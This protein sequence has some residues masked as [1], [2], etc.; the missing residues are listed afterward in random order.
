MS[1]SYQRKDIHR[2]SVEEGL[3]VPL[4]GRIREVPYVEATSFGRCSNDSF[5]LC[6]VDRLA[7]GGSST[8]FLDGGGSHA[9]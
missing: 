5:I 1:F 2:V 7:A 8:G 6:S 3:E 4:S 9:A